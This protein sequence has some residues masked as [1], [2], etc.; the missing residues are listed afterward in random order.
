MSAQV[1][2]SVFAV[3]TSCVVARET[4]HCPDFVSTTS[5]SYLDYV[6]KRYFVIKNKTFFTI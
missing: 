1:V 5:V 3:D 6:A 4:A 2:E